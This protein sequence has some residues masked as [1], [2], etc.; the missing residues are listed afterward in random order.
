I[1]MQLVGKGGQITLWIPANMA[2]GS[3]G[4]GSIGPNEALQFKVELHD[5]ITPETAAEEK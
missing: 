4:S 1:G 5:I 2:Y 3:G